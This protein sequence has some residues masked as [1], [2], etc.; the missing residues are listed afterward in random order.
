MVQN[1]GRRLAPLGVVVR[2]LTGDMQL[3]KGEIMK[4]QVCAEQDGPMAWQYIG[5][6][7]YCLYLNIA[8]TISF[9]VQLLLKKIEHN[10][11]PCNVKLSFR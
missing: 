4:T 1:F 11:I 3:T 9:Q 2:E 6:V 7:Y 5:S 10:I 8:K